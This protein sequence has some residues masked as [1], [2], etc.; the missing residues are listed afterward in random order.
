MIKAKKKISYVNNLIFLI[1]KG[2]LAQEVNGE[3]STG[4]AVMR[5]PFIMVHF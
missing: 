1:C 4:A 3:K 2:R 5:G